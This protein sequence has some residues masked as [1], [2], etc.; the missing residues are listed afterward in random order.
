M[1]QVVAKLETNFWQVRIKSALCFFIALGCQ[2]AFGELK[3]VSFL[4]VYQPNRG[5]CESKFNPSDS[6][7]SLSDAKIELARSRLRNPLGPVKKYL[8]QWLT[9]KGVT[10]ERLAATFATFAQAIRSEHIPNWD[11]S[12]SLGSSSVGGTIVFT[13]TGGHAVIFSPGPLI[14]IEEPITLSGDLGDLTAQKFAI[15]APDRV[16]VYF[17]KIFYPNFVFSE[18]PNTPL[19]RWEGF[20]YPQFL[21]ELEP[22]EPSPEML[23]LPPPQPSKNRIFPFRFPFG[24]NQN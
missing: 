16:H 4:D 23:P 6:L 9:V 21:D 14:P 17:G 18:D 13:G 10:V 15:G 2:W 5:R 19:D 8:S 22:T 12:V 3:Q 1:R 24:R 11:M 7:I 20:A